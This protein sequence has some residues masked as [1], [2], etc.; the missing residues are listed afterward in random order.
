MFGKNPCRITNDKMFLKSVKLR[1]GNVIKLREIQR[2][3]MF[4]EI[5][6]PKVTNPS[7][8]VL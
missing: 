6:M 5:K 2:I 8:V 4:I 1:E 7:G 3:S